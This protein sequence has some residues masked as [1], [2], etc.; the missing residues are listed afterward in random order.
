MP[1]LPALLLIDS[2]A[3]LPKLEPHSLIP[4]L[5]SSRLD[6]I[7]LLALCH[8]LWLANALLPS[9]C[10]VCSSHLISPSLSVALR[11]AWSTTLHSLLLLVFSSSLLASSLPPSLDTASRHRR[12]LNSG[13]F[14][15][16]SVPI[17]I[18]QHSV[19]SP[20]GP[21]PH[22]PPE[23]IDCRDLSTSRSRALSKTCADTTSTSRAPGLKRKT[24]MRPARQQNGR[25]RDRGERGEVQHLYAR[26]NGTISEY[27]NTESP[28]QSN[29][30][31]ACGR[32]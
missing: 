3:S 12:L 4:S 14:L 26:K 20:L 24:A 5:H 8:S 7:S 10:L 25:P 19:Q 28:R 2:S 23:R 29:G 9:F 15:L 1:P 22:P 32:E 30:A 27:Q 21:R 16:P 6:S 13:A 31:L 18:S 17:T 11:P